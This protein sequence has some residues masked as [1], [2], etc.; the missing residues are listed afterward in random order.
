MN[1]WKL[2]SSFGAGHWEAALAGG[3]CGSQWA[4]KP[5]AKVTGEPYLATW[6]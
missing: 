6:G 4:A 1:M 5:V 2:G 3:G